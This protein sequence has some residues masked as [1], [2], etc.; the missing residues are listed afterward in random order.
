MCELAQNLYES[1]NK[2]GYLHAKVEIYFAIINFYARPNSEIYR[3]CLL[4][5][6]LSEPNIKL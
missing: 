1:T 5:D 6:A 3:F 4:Y 2:S